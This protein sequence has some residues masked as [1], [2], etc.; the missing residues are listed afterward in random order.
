[1][2]AAC[3]RHSDRVQ[4]LPSIFAPS[5]N[6]AVARQVQRLSTEEEELAMNKIALIATGLLIATSAAASAN[7]IDAT[8]DRQA[9]RIEH[10]RETGK[11]TWTEGLKLRAEQNR[12]ARTEAEYKE[13]GYLTKSERRDLRER[14]EEAAEHISEK[15]N[16]GWS[17]V[18]WLP[19][20][21]R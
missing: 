19:R 13:K 14:Q 7:S 9:D 21:G 3:I 16:N 17:R 8:R 4:R 2:N 5:N 18:W 11:I 20:F 10:G 1:M 15:K 6:E 12:I